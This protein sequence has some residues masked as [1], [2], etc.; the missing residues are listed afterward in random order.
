MKYRTYVGCAS[1]LPLQSA[2]AAAW[3]DELHVEKSREIYK[4]NFKVAKEILGI[5]IP[6]ATFYVWLKVHNPIEF[7]KKLYKDYN[8]KV[9]PGEFLAREN[10]DGINPGKEF[11]RIALVEG[12][13]KTKS[14][15]VRI[16][17]CLDG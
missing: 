9:L 17:E 15:L 6:D 13:E 7:T 4:N 2:A 10:K 16:K 5:D 8:V 1:P 12:V 11:V 14:A 3:K